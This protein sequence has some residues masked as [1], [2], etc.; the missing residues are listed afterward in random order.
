MSFDLNRPR[1]RERDRERERE[2]SGRRLGHRRE[3]K[4]KYTVGK[5]LISFRERW[6]FLVLGHQGAR[7]SLCFRCLRAPGYG[8]RVTSVPVNVKGEHACVCMCVLARVIIQI[9]M[10]SVGINLTGC[11]CW[12]VSG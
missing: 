12:D 5:S 2:R 4:R 9:K 1:E 8:D 11:P 3:K 10:A 7:G 6:L